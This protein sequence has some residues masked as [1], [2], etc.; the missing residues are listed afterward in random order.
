MTKI[1]KARERVV[2]AL[3]QLIED[4]DHD[5]EFAKDCRRCQHIVEAKRACA[6]LA[7]AQRRRK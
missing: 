7:A 4:S 1:A 6:A 2:K 3:S 5:G